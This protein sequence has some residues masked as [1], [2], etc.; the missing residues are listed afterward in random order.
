MAPVCSY[1]S[2]L[3]L[4]IST[5]LFGLSASLH[6]TMFQKN[7]ICLFSHSSLMLYL[8]AHD[9]ASRERKLMST[10]DKE[11]GDAIKTGDRRSEIE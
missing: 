1:A 8:N 6:L 5:C 7:N 10:A 2:I 3:L 4:V 11:Q 9:V